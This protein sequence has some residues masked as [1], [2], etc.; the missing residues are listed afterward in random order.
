MALVLSPKILGSTVEM[1]G[2]KCTAQNYAK[3]LFFG[4][5][6]NWVVTQLG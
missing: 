5:L 6:D 1:F 2:T 3:N 4:S